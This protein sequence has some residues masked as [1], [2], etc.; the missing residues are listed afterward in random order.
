MTDRR[1]S[2]FRALLKGGGV[3]FTGLVVELGVS[4]VAKVLIAQYLGRVDYGAVSIGVTLMAMTSTLVLVGLNIGIGRYLPR[5]EGT[6]HRRGVLVSAFQIALPLS[7][8][9]GAAVV[10]AAPWLAGTV[11]RDPDIAPVLRVFGAAIPLAA[12]MKLALGS[13]QGLQTSVPKVT[14][15]NLTVPLVRFAGIVVV[16]GLGAGVTGVAWAYLVSYLAAAALGVYYLHDRTTLFSRVEYEPMHRELLSFSAPLVVTAAM[17]LVFSD[18]DT[19]MISALTG[20]TGDV[21]IYNVVYPLAM[22]LTAVSSAFG[23]LFMPVISELHAEGRTD[24]MHRIYVVV[25]KWVFVATFPLLLPL[26]LFPRVAIGITFGGEYVG[27]ALALSILAVGFFLHVVVGPNNDILTSI[28]R[29]RLLMYDNAV[30]AAVNVALNLV[31]IPRYS[32]LGAAVA[33]TASYL[34]LTALFA[35]QLYAET[36]IHPLTRTLLRPAAV[37]V[38]L[39]AGLYGV[40]LALFE[41]SLLVSVGYFGVLLPVY[42]VVVLRLAVEREEVMLLWSLEERLDTDL[43]P[44]KRVLRW[45]IE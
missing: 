28:G 1:D 9:V 2:A 44:V 22:L 15:E 6:D 20:K 43:G 39:A 21:G 23:F 31:L 3:V 19:F 37:T 42:A 38:V 36:G 24:D 32:F 18:I 40:V 29:T 35:H 10:V 13:I 25:V 7:V 4:L 5:V 26:L 27:G 12:L 11:F 34:V 30:A 14:V 8:L 17:T 33:T 16:L 45:V 41:R